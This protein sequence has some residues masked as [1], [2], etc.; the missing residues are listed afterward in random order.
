MAALRSSRAR[1]PRP[2][3]RRAPPPPLAH[4]INS[5]I[6]NSIIKLVRACVHACV[7]VCRIPYSSHRSFPAPGPRPPPRRA[8]PRHLCASVRVPCFGGAR[9][10]ESIHILANYRTGHLRLQDLINGFAARRSLLRHRHHR[11]RSH[12]HEPREDGL[13]GG[14]NADVV[15]AHVRF[16]VGGVLRAVA[17]AGVRARARIGPIWSQMAGGCSNRSRAVSHS[18]RAVTRGGAG[19]RA[20]ARSGWL[21]DDALQSRPRDPRPCPCPARAPPLHCIL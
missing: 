1:E 17:G 4:S 14:G 9:V 8:P 16:R 20:R 21:V 15:L 5:I 19:M 18:Q 7:C 2:P 13:G 11:R 12:G 3:P 10:T 6:K